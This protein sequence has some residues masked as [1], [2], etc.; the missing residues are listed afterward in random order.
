MGT[1]HRDPDRIGRRVVVA[2]LVMGLLAGCSSGFPETPSTPLVSVRA[3]P[4]E[5]AE[6]DTISVFLG[7]VLGFDRI[8]DL[9]A[10]PDQKQSKIHLFGAGG[11]YIRSFGREGFGPGEL[12]VITFLRADPVGRALWVVSN[13]GTKLIHLTLDDDY[14]GGFSLPFS[15]TASFV[16]LPDRRIVMTC[17]D[18]AMKGSL[19]CLDE[20]GDVLWRASPP[21]EFD[22]NRGFLPAVN[23]SFACLVGGEVW[24]VYDAFNI[25]RVF[26]PEGGLLREFHVR[27]RYLEEQ[28]AESVRLHRDFIRGKKNEQGYL[29]PVK[30]IL[31]AARGGPDRCYLLAASKRSTPESE[32]WRISVYVVESDGEVMYHYEWMDAPGTARGIVPLEG[33]GP[34]RAALLM[35]TGLD[36]PRIHIVREED[37]TR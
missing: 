10:I 23:G 36:Q 34:F 21:L 25:I 19:A 3:F 13:V 11:E 28:H 8:G 26:S 31:A 12:N 7:A 20:E 4:P 35:R 14:L 9:F 27:E 32:A 24:Q 29:V 16:P 17:P 22:G 6:G 2:A 1:G 30:R 15:G 37:P 33:G 5:P 18:A